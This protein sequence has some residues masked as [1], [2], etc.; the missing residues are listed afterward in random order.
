MSF[1]WEFLCIFPTSNTSSTKTNIVGD[2][3]CLKLSGLFDF[4]LVILTCHLCAAM[5]ESPLPTTHGTSPSPL[6]AS[7]S[8][9]ELPQLPPASQQHQQDDVDVQKL[10]DLVK[11]LEKQN[12]HLRNRTGRLSGS[13]SR[14][15]CVKYCVFNYYTDTCWFLPAMRTV[16]Y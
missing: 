14:L 13:V 5:N 16:L 9:S 12:E 8:A 3:T 11:K 15:I 10:K 2:D 7:S 4:S 6:M 1:E